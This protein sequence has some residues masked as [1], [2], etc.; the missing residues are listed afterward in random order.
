M[1]CPRS[2]CDR[3]AA[4]GPFEPGRLDGHRRDFQVAAG[5]SG[6]NQTETG[7]RQVRPE[8]LFERA[9]EARDLRVADLDEDASA[10][11]LTTGPR[12]TCGARSCEMGGTP[13]D[14]RPGKGGRTGRPRSVGRDGGRSRSGRS[15][16]RSPAGVTDA[17]ISGAQRV[18][19]SPRSIGAERLPEFGTGHPATAVRKREV[20]V[21]VQRD[22]RP[23]FAS[24][25]SA[26]RKRAA[27][28][29]RG[30]ISPAQVDAAEHAAKDRDGERPAG[31]RP[32]G[33]RPAAAGEPAPRPGRNAVGSR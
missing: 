26:A 11:D 31:E 9:C 24:L 4:R 12:P 14:S 30:R 2:G 17:Y 23:P 22:G 10:A 5:A 25:W 3:G 13:Q 21:D 7:Q 20:P 27:V 18:T 19:V 29:I 6:K 15:G 33:H 16:G 28:R 8:G 32:P 1:R